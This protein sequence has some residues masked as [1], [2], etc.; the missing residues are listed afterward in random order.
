M[1]NKIKILYT[2]PNFN[3]AGS[4]IP[5][6]KIA[7]SLDSN[8]FEPHIACLHDKGDLFQDVKK[9]VLKSI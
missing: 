1:N 5:V 3:T 7:Q 9:V 2:I 6:F 8:I 4:G